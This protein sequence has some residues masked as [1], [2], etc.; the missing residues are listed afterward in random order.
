MNRMTF[1]R[2]MILALVLVAAATSMGGAQGGA[3]TFVETYS[4]AGAEPCEGLTL[5]GITYSFTVGGAPSLDCD[6]RTWIGPG[7]TNNI[8]APNIEG[9]AAGVLHLTLDVPTTS[10]GFGVARS[11]PNLGSNDS[12]IIDLYR[13]GAGLLREEIFLNPT[14]DPLFTGG[15]YD[16]KGPAVKTVAIAFRTPP[17]LRFV[18]DNLTYFRPPGQVNK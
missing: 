12:V 7:V 13:P 5:H 3:P 16:Y 1:S 14:A 10:F 4:P 9:T 17:A 15:R 2:S 18:L 6:A 11:I 8:Q